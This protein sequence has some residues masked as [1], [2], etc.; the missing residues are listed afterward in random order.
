M[1]PIKNSVENSTTEWQLDPQLARDTF[2][3]GELPLA[4]VLGM[5]DANYPWLIL[6]PR[7]P[8]AREILD[9]PARQ[10]EQLFDEIVMLSQVL[11]DV[12]GCDKL[13]IAAIGNVVAQWLVHIAA[14]RKDD[15]AWPKPVWGAAPAQPY[16]DEAREKFIASIRNEVAFG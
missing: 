4:R 16:G 5:N 15:A 12:T 14:R 8:G 7:Q 1:N 9:L 3:I 13:N 11:K 2:P 6:V 10:Q